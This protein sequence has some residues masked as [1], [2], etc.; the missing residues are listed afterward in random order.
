MRLTDLS[1]AIAAG[2]APIVELHG[3]DPMIYVAF[4]RSADGLAPL[5]D[6]EE[7][8]L[9]YPSRHAACTALRETGL[10]SVQFVHRS[11]YDEMIGLSS[12]DGGAEL[13][14]LLTL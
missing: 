6:D 1:D 4:A 14:E 13:R 10:A 9:K 12:V 3:V 2:Q 7:R 8:V 5:K 11:A